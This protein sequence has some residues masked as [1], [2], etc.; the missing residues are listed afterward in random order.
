[1][2]NEIIILLASLFTSIT[3]LILAIVAIINLKVVRNHSK[4]IEKQLLILRNE[5]IPFLEIK[6]I[7]YDNNKINIKLKNKSENPALDIRSSTHFVPLKPSKGQ[8]MWDFIFKLKDNKPG[9]LGKDCWSI[10]AMTPLKDNKKRW[11]LNPKDEGDFSTNVN[12]FVS[13]NKPRDRFVPKMDEEYGQ[14][15]FFEEMVELLKYNKVR[16]CSINLMIKYSDINNEYNQ[17]EP[18]FDYIMDLTKHKTL[19]DVVSDGIPFIQRSA[20]KSEFTTMPEQIWED[21]KDQR[22]FLD[23]LK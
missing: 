16:Y 11:Q 1:M 22:S 5:K 14:I 3:S 15:L 23:K 21:L 20:H 19:K 7:D 6:K 8:Q 13:F 9:R 2:S 17:V 18:V 4:I 10:R 12:F